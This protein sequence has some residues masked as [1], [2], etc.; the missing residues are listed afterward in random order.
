M[1]RH[2]P[3]GATAVVTAGTAAVFAGSTVIIA[4]AALAVVGTS[5]LTSMG[6]V[7]GDA[8]VAAVLM[9]RLSANPTPHTI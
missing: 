1:G 5:F 8:V 4:L 6:L 2:G 3:I 9:N 7:A